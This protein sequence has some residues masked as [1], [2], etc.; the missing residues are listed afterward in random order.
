MPARLPS[1]PLAFW[2]TAAA[3]LL[4]FATWSNSFVAIGFLL[5]SEGAPARF[6][7]IGLTAA[8]FVPAA[9]LAAGYCLLF[10][11][12][13]AAALVRTEWR[14][15]LA[16]GLFAVPAYNLA[17][18]YGQQSGVPAPVASLTTAL[19]PL[20][21]MALAVLFLG[22]ELTRARLLGFTVSASG[23]V[24]IA[25]AEREEAAAAYPALV[26]ITALAPLAWSLYTVLAKPL[27]GRASPLVWTYLVIATGG[28]LVLP[29][30][31]AGAFRQIVALD[32]AGWLAL[33]FLVL[34][35]TVVGFAVWT[36][37]L[38]HLP[39]SSVGFT[40][41]L[42]PPLTALS[43]L[44]LATL[45]PAS[46]VFAIEPREWLGGLVALCGLAIALWRPMATGLAARRWGAKG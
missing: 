17:L 33:A 22:E 39:A 40:V 16:S 38:R 5:G 27:V 26:A 46:F 3:V 15:L 21:V 8:R 31:P 34:P 41:F 32:A 14:R 4:L 43:K 45:F 12:R 44:L 10:R 25:L 1:S 35:C 6:D 24:V 18:Y 37:L 9:A 36:W 11:R 30:L 42:N 13:E 20:F 29:L 23:M 28:V 2:A 19:L 7:W